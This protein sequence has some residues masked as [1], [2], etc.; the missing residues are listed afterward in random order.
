[1]FVTQYSKEW[2][3]EHKCPSTQEWRK[4]KC[5]LIMDCTIIPPRNTEELTRVTT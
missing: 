1:M 3:S 4:T 2:G 5:A